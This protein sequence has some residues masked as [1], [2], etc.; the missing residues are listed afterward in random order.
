M[1]QSRPSATLGGGAEGANLPHHIQANRGPRR[2]IATNQDDP[3]EVNDWN[4]YQELL[5]DGL[6][7]SAFSWR[8]LVRYCIDGGLDRPPRR[9]TVGVS[10]L[11]VR[12]RLALKDRPLGQLR[13]CFV[14]LLAFLGLPVALSQLSLCEILAAG[15]KR[16]RQPMPEEDRSLRAEVLTRWRLWSQPWPKCGSV[17]PR[18][19]RASCIQS[20][21]SP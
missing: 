14:Q 6:A 3:G 13:E 4:I 21:W 2:L 1:P 11:R 7:L 5:N 20:A 15:T 9:A 8:M 16:F 10:A 12:V 19:R 18:T 17:N